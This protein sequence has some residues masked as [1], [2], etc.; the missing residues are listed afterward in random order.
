MIL[1][2]IFQVV[3]YLF[4]LHNFCNFCNKSLSVFGISTV[5]IQK[6]AYIFCQ[7]CEGVPFL[8]DRILVQVAK[9]NQQWAW[10]LYPVKRLRTSPWQAWYHQCLV[11]ACSA[12]LKG[13]I[14]YQLYEGIQSHIFQ[15]TKFSVLSLS[16]ASSESDIFLNHMNG[17]Q[18]NCTSH[19]VFTFRKWRENKNNVV[20]VLKLG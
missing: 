13:Y 7:L 19:V 12:S 1:K 4:R 8:P 3:A 6:D 18:D 9:L 10:H 11:S 20:N 2:H 14:F 5:L 16:R 17:C 15:V